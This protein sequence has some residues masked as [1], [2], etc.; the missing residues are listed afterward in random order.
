MRQRGVVLF[1]MVLS[2]T[3]L[4][5]RI[6]RGG[7]ITDDDLTRLLRAG[8]AAIYLLLMAVALTCCCRCGG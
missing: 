1:I 2:V 3:L 7:C 6:A 5:G 8:N 4:L